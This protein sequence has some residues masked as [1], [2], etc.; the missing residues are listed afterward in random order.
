MLDRR[1]WNLDD[2]DAS[3]VDEMN[4]MDVAPFDWLAGLRL[5]VS[6]L[7]YLFRRSLFFHRFVHFKY[8]LR[9]DC[10]L[11]LQR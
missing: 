1:R 5:V 2:A 3:R 6:L 8:S 9:V 4:V 11:R 7:T 10:D